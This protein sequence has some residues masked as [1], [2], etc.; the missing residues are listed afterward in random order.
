MHLPR[1]PNRLDLAG[2]VA[3]TDQAEAHPLLQ[4]FLGDQGLG[5]LFYRGAG[6]VDERLHAASHVHHE[7]DVDVGLAVAEDD[8]VGAGLALAVDDAAPIATSFPGFMG[9]M[10]GLGA[11]IETEAAAA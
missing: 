3:K 9:L 11:T 5:Q 4:P 8:R 10:E 1:Q 6:I 2:V 7:Y